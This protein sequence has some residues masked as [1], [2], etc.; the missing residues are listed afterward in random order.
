MLLCWLTFELLNCILPWLVFIT[1]E[2]YFELECFINMK[3]LVF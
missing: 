1:I 3:K 2:A